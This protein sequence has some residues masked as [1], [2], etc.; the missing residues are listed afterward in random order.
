MASWEKLWW[1]E[2]VRKWGPVEEVDTQSG[3]Q[4]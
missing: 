2:E 3:P 1:R 4:Q